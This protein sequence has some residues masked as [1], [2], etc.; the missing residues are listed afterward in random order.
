S[1]SPRGGR[2]AQ[3]RRRNV[4]E[5]LSQNRTK[6]NQQ[7]EPENI[8][9]QS[10]QEFPYLSEDSS[11][12][13]AR[14]DSSSD[15]MLSSLT[16]QSYSRNPL[17]SSRRNVMSAEDFPALS[18]ATI[19][20][21]SESFNNQSRKINTNT[22]PPQV[23]RVNVKSTEDFPT[24]SSIITTT[25]SEGP[26]NQG[27]KMTNNSTKPHTASLKTSNV[28]SQSA[29][30]NVPTQN[31]STSS[32]DSKLKRTDLE[33][34]DKAS[35]S[36]SKWAAKKSNFNFEE[37]FPTLEVKKN[38]P[39]F[40]AASVPKVS[41]SASNN[42]LTNRAPDPVV[43]KN[44][45]SSNTEYT[46]GDHFVVIKTKS[47]KKKPSRIY[48]PPDGD[49]TEEPKSVSYNKIN[50]IEND[51]NRNIFKK[52]LSQP[53]V[54]P[55]PKPSDTWGDDN[56][57]FGNADF[58]PLAPTEPQ[59]KPPGL[60]IAKSRAPPPPPGFCANSAITN[61]SISNKTL[62]D[63][64]REIVLPSTVNGVNH[65][66]SS[67][68]DTFQAY[69]EPP[70]FLQR[71][72]EL[73]KKIYD[74]SN[75]QAFLFQEFKEASGKFRRDE[76]SASEYHAKC[77]NI[78]GEKAIVEIFPELVSLLPDIKKQQELLTVHNLYLSQINHGAISKKLAKK[79]SNSLVS[80]QKCN[81][82]LEMSDCKNHE[83]LHNRNGSQ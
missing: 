80:C 77:L 30:W 22:N 82:V 62:G 59:K 11:N 58:P 60:S 9:T 13:T 71:N 12:R 35:Q 75:A 16:L 54:P 70:N 19:T 48:T 51:E 57:S 45:S 34:G 33:S 10:V 17:S 36:K 14:P 47:K 31:V 79:F 44:S 4:E 1:S 68:K 27:K 83:L 24:L 26:N 21:P 42:G 7:P 23:Q 76:I 8:D 3:N 56:V 28:T 40:A 6:A 64:A 74:L 73:I 69:R 53:T 43:L 65:Q 32:N 52:H 46:S 37:E 72:N 38:P 20:T 66:E 49:A 29:Q 18:S 2:F 67:N 41:S 5:N 55:R 81:Q 63:V 25:S 50:M 78:L 61:S 15:T 39:P